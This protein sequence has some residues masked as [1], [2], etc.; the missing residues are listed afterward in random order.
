MTADIPRLLADGT[1]PLH[2]RDFLKRLEAMEIEHGTVEHVAVYTVAESQ[3]LRGEF[4][5]A[6][7]KNLFLR[8]KEGRMWLVTCLA[9]TI[10]E[11]GKKEGLRCVRKT[12]LQALSHTQEAFTC[13]TIP[14]DSL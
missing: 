4:H 7:V 8:N 11:F 12:L 13:E 14:H 2:A 5:G 10:H 6:H 3:A 9:R 1:E